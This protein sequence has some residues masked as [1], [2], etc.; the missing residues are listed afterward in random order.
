MQSFLVSIYML[1]F[2]GVQLQMYG[3]LDA[4]HGYLTF[5]LPRAGSSN[6][7]MTISINLRLNGKGT[8]FPPPHFRVGS[9]YHFPSHGLALL[10]S[11]GNVVKS[12]KF[13][14]N[15]CFT[16]KPLVS[17]RLFLNGIPPC[18]SLRFLKTTQ[19]VG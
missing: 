9:R 13:I 11:K 12:N 10:T 3:L 14:P 1:N 7:R 17:S 4:G 6:L 8:I 5:K 18:T 2:W 16:E 19:K 15:R